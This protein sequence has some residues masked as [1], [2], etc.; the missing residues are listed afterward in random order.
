MYA[1]RNLGQNILK[2]LLGVNIWKEKLVET[3][4]WNSL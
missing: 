4:I 1:R 2:Y 3:I